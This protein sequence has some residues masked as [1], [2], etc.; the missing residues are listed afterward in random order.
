MLA[1]HYHNNSH[2]AKWQGA[3]LKSIIIAKLCLYL[4]PSYNNMTRKQIL[5]VMN[6]FHEYLLK[7]KV[8]YRKSCCSN[9]L[10]SRNN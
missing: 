3:R 10:N 2:D 5:L 9:T 8:Y 6:G 1:A 4:K 7:Y